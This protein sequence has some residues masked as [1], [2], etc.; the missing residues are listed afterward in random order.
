MR[1]DGSPKQPKV[2]VAKLEF[3]SSFLETNWLEFQALAHHF[4]GQGTEKF[5]EP[6]LGNGKDK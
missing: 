4:L 3:N 1:S 6:S 5:I 2:G